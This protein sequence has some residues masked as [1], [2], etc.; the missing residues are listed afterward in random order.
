MR[1]TAMAAGPPPEER[2]KMVSD[3]GAIAAHGSAAERAG[4]EDE[5]F[6]SRKEDDKW[7]AMPAMDQASVPR[8]I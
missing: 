3:A 2:A 5:T 7:P 6:A 8:L 4:Q 1:M